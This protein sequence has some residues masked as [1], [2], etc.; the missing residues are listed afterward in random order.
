MVERF[1]RYLKTAIR[2]RLTSPNWIRELPWVL[3]GIRTAP[4][5]D[6]GCSSADIVY[7]AP[8]TVSGDFIPSGSFHSDDLLRSRVYDNVRSLVPIPTTSHSNSTTSVPRSLHLSKFVFICCDAHRTPFQR[9]YCGPYKVVEHDQK[10]FKVDIGGK[11]DIVSVDRIKPAHIDPDFPTPV[12]E[13]RRRGRPH[14]SANVD[15]TDRQTLPTDGRIR[16][17]KSCLPNSSVRF[18][19]GV[20]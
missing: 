3:L 4:R 13:S 16:V 15:P 5:E 8:L 14:K 18:L 12:A 6:L 1:H 11:T 17:V 7:G 9:P 2:A 19:G 10:Y 20:V